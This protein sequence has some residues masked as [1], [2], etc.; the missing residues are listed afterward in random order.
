M[1]CEV[2]GYGISRPK[3]VHQECRLV[4]SIAL[5]KHSIAHFTAN[6]VPEAA[7][8]NL[9]DHSCS[10]CLLHQATVLTLV[11]PVVKQRVIVQIGHKSTSPR[12]QYRARDGANPVFTCRHEPCWV[13]GHQAPFSES[14]TECQSLLLSI[15][16]LDSDP[17][18]LGPSCA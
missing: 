14:C 18:S 15:W 7:C 13:C 12:Q 8:L 4:V 10:I 16:R 11:A 3:D 9:L 1:L 5:S 6:Y 17:W 2:P